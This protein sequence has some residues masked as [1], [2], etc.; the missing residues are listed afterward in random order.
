MSKGAESRKEYLQVAESYYNL[1]CLKKRVPDYNTYVKEYVHAIHAANCYLSD[2][3]ITLEGVRT[4]LIR[5]FSTTIAHV[6]VQDGCVRI[7]S[8]PVQE[9]HFTIASPFYL[10]SELPVFYM[11]N[12]PSQ[13]N[14]CCDLSV[15][16]YRL[17]RK[18]TDSRFQIMNT[19]IYNGSYLKMDD[20][21]EVESI[22]TI[23]GEHGV[24][25]RWVL[26]I[27][28]PI[29]LIKQENGAE[30]TPADLRTLLSWYEFNISNKAIIRGDKVWYGSHNN[31]GEGRVESSYFGSVV[32][33]VLVTGYC[34]R[35]ALGHDAKNIFLSFN[36]SGVLRD[37]ACAI[38]EIHR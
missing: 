31:Y 21:F 7:T 17:S 19:H 29:Q 18:A 26:D 16:K 13:L 15:D 22:Y 20:Q 36:N 27:Y 5:K 25:A 35:E 6:G 38:A 24:S 14:M 3:N 4:A 28:I 32:S 9:N 34:S 23:R 30:I 10:A 37:F 8:Y 12:V 11:G 2:G 33:P 1:L